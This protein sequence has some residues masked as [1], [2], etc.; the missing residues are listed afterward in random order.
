VPYLSYLSGHTV[1]HARGLAVGPSGTVFVAGGSNPG[2]QQ[3]GA[4]LPRF[5]DPHERINPNAFVAAFEL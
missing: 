5:H 2:L 3:T 4:H 1:T